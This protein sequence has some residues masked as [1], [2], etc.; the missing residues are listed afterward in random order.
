ML[1]RSCGFNSGKNSE[2]D[3]ENK[4]VE[5]RNNMLI[6]D[7][8]SVFE[9]LKIFG[10]EG[11]RFLSERTGKNIK[12][13]TKT[14]LSK[15]LS[16]FKGKGKGDDINE[17]V[18]GFE[19]EQERG[20]KKMDDLVNVNGLLRKPD[21]DKGKI[22]DRGE[23]SVIRSFEV[24]GLDDLFFK[25]K[26]VYL[27][28]ADKKGKM[29]YQGGKI[30]EEMLSKFAM[31]KITEFEQ[32][33]VK[34]IVGKGQMDKETAID[35]IRHRYKLSSQIEGLPI[36]E[37][38]E[39]NDG[40]KRVELRSD[41]FLTFNSFDTLQEMEEKHA[42]VDQIIE[43]IMKETASDNEIVYQKKEPDGEEKF[44][45]VESDINVLSV[46]PIFLNKILFDFK[47]QAVG[48]VDYYNDYY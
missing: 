13:K 2:L 43:N 24:Y 15:A 14:I 18:S 28:I 5:K 20:E 21:L 36:F 47:K 39:I 31:T 48:N 25:L 37:L 33:V 38:V 16:L 12:E 40:K 32:R 26:N 44:P 17:M 8:D 30:T 34:T 23:I 10:L 22:E 9:Q 41:N 29:N 6:E 4:N 35:F 27:E 11:V 42:S 45:K 46:E 7:R 1:G 3:I 19:Q